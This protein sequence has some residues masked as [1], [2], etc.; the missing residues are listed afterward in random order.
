MQFPQELEIKGQKTNT[1]GVG[2]LRWG[3]PA[4]EHGLICP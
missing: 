4:E 2:I 3:I 1:L